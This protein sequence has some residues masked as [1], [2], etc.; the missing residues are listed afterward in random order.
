MIWPFFFVSEATGPG[1]CLLCYYQPLCVV[2]QQSWFGLFSF[3]KFSNFAP[4]PPIYTVHVHVSAITCLEILS[5]SLLPI[6][7]RPSRWRTTQQARWSVSGPW[8]LRNAWTA[9]HIR[10]GIWFELNWTKMNW[11]DE[12]NGFWTVWR[13]KYPI[14]PVLWDWTDLKIVFLS[15]RS[16]TLT[17]GPFVVT[18]ET[19]DIVAGDT[20]AFRVSFRWE[21]GGGL[22]VPIMYDITLSK[23][24]TDISIYMIW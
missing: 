6:S 11:T 20:M 18:P 22:S 14:F 21:G 24:C 7:P 1:L 19:A 3:H 12:W 9:S 15:N 10:G 8:A 23:Y 16:D 2:S 5:Y 17:T 4:P 13:P